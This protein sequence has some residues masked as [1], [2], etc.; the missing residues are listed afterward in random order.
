MMTAEPRFD[1]REKNT[2][3]DLQT[4]L[5]GLAL[6][7]WEHEQPYEYHALVIRTKT[8]AW[9]K[10][11]LIAT[12]QS[13]MYYTEPKGIG[14]EEER[15]H[16]DERGVVTGFG[17]LVNFKVQVTL[18]YI[19]GCRCA[20]LIANHGATETQR[21]IYQALQRELDSLPA[22]AASERL[23]LHEHVNGRIAQITDAVCLFCL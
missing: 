7:A 1:L 2:E 4:L 12:V 5:N 17:H 20:S 14:T 3:G 11:Y 21:I 22:S 9:A 13:P 19:H 8:E 18:P 16:L 23:A 15:K 10:N 6:M